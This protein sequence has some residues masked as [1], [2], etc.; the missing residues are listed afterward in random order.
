MKAHFDNQTAFSAYDITE[1]INDKIDDGEWEVMNFNYTATTP[2]KH[3][4]V[5]A[6]I[7]ELYENKLFYKDVT[8]NNVTDS[9][10]QVYELYSILSL[11][12]LTFALPQRN[13]MIVMTFKLISINSLGI[14]LLRI[15][16]S[17]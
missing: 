16:I 10:G 4:T 3:Q 15:L 14:H 12:V 9:L 7:D 13:L 2:V 1:F 8:C 11:S 17:W 5:E 6:Y